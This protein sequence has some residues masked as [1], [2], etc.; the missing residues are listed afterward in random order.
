VREAEGEAEDDP[1]L[2]LDRE[3]EFDK[4]TDAERVTDLVAVGER[5]TDPVGD[6]VLLRV[7]ELEIGVPWLAQPPSYG[8]SVSP[9]WRRC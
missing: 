6:D 1:E 4:V 2:V 9:D 5:V 8:V 3:D 7:G